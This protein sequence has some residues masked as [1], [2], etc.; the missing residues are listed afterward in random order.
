MACM[1]ELPDRHEQNKKLPSLLDANLQHMI[2]WDTYCRRYQKEIAES[3]AVDHFQ[4]EYKDYRH[5]CI[6]G[7]ATRKRKSHSEVLVRLLNANPL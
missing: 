7:T 2:N 3:H 4:N 5:I 6:L 1:E